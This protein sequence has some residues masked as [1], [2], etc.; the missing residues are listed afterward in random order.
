MAK[1][2]TDPG[3]GTRFITD[4]SRLIN[5]D[6]TY[7]VKRSGGLSPLQ[8]AYYYLVNISWQKFMVIIFI[9][10]LLV[11]IF[12]A[13]IYFQFDEGCLSGS[14]HGVSSFSVYMKCF[15][16]SVQTMTT[17]G[18]GHIYPNCHSTQIAATCESL[19]GLMTLA[20]MTGILYGRFSKPTARIA[21]STKAV[22]APYEDK[23]GF[24]VRIAN[25]RHAILLQANVNVLYSCNV[26]N[27]KGETIRDY[28]RMP[29]EID[30]IQAMPLSWTLVHPID[31]N[32]PM[33]NKTADDMRKE[34]AEILVMFK[35]FDETYHNDVHARFSFTA[36][37]TVFN[38]RFKKTF[39]A[40]PDGSVLLDLNTIGD[41]ELVG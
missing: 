19:T 21:H 34:H 37:E 8:D 35:A 31:E 9:S 29:L 32:S 40:Q 27:D 4:A 3:T 22:V 15:Y 20:V 14:L 11:N 18:Y 38:A 5:A 41:Y 16:F 13:F 2:G 28:Y 10:F 25:K 26:T 30:V 17:I 23:T 7:N 39:H 33:Y 1:K 36:N 12:F 24:M 6:G